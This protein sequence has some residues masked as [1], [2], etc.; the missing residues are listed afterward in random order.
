MVPVVSI[1]VPVYNSEK[2]LGRCIDSI[3]SQ[4]Y[5]DFELL[6]L[7]DGSTDSSGQICDMY[8]DK[9]KRIR[10]V[11]NEKI[12]VSDTRNQGIAIAR[13]EYLQFVD[14]DDWIT[15]NATELFVHTAEEYQCDMV[16]ADF[17]RVIGERVSKKG[18]IDKEGL[19]D[20]AG[21]AAYMMQKPADFY[22]GVL[23][24]K[25]FKRSIVD[26]CKLK[27]ESSISWCEDFIFNLEYIRNI[28]T[29]YVMKLP[30]YYYV[31]TKGSLVSQSMSVKKVIQMK[32]MVFG[33]YNNFYK[34]VFDEEEYEK[35]RGQIYRFLIDSASDGKVA[36]SNKRGNY[37]LG[38]E[39]INISDGVKTGEGFLFD[40]YLERKLQEMLLEEV[41]LKHDLSVND[42]ILLYLLSRSSVN[43]TFNEMAAILGITRKELKAAVQSLLDNELIQAREKAEKKPRK[44]NKGNEDH[45]EKKRKMDS[46]EYVVT[47]SADAILSNIRSVLDEFE[48]IQY[49]G[50]STDEIVIYKKLNERRN[51]NIRKTL[52]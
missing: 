45:T 26:K 10:V 8:A 35:R 38:T 2:T 41:A 7:N 9:D 13:G 16:I 24:N 1:I 27:M 40:V 42:V 4:T 52:C 34:D 32:R 6:L 5:K 47:Q 44:N 36:L 48:Q 46:W 33:Y 39:R 49:G 31:K 14:S 17:Y 18:A 25:F 21:Y 37:R 15:P 22:Y 28:K 43:G 12:G 50:F 51:Q 11:H 19:L 23:W 20:R 3:L 29:V 30:I